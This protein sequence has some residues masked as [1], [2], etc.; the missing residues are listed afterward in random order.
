MPILNIALIEGRSN[1]QK[2]ALISEV[3]D[4]CVRALGVKPETV[5]ILL[6]DIATQ[7]FGVAGESVRVKRER[8]A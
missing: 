2:E 3:T 6:Q 5:R 4:A 1:E 8:Q 7:D